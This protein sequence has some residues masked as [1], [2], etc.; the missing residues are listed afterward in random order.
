MG[1]RKNYIIYWVKSRYWK[2]RNKVYSIEIKNWIIIVSLLIII[3]I[4]SNVIQWM[5]NKDFDVGTI[6][7]WFSGIATIL[8]A[9]ISLNIAS[10]K[11]MIK[12]HLEIVYADEDKITINVTNVGKGIVNY[13]VVGIDVV[14]IKEQKR[15]RELREPVLNEA[16][17]EPNYGVMKMLNIGETGKVVDINA[18]YLEPYVQP[19]SEIDAAFEIE[20]WLSDESRRN[21]LV[22]HR[23][24]SWMI[25]GND[26]SDIK[27]PRGV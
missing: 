4:F 15:L 27:L 21:I 26:F 9:F 10:R 17:P 7:D 20:I 3:L 6:A 14:G 25:S 12:L 22:I 11:E 16:I 1:K 19:Y 18:R 5:N 2:I 23:V 24:G 13:S 8:V